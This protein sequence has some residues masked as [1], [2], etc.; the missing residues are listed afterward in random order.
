MKITAKVAKVPLKQAFEE[1]F[2][3]NGLGYVVTSKEGD[4]YDGLVVIKQGGE[5][6][7]PAGQAPAPEKAPAKEKVVKEKPVEK[8]KEKP[9][10]DGDKAELVAASRLKLIKQLIDDGKADRAKMRLQ[11]LLKEYPKTKAADEAR[12][13]LKKLSK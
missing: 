10:E 4:A 9:E 13:L 12:E 2:K 5:R 11:D 3:T 7:Y 6:G 1:M 8:A